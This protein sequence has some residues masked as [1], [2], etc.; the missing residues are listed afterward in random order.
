VFQQCLKENAI[1]VFWKPLKIMKQF[2]WYF[3][4]FFAGKIKWVLLTNLELMCIFF[5]AH[6]RLVQY[7]E[8]IQGKTYFCCAECSLNFV[9]LLFDSFNLYE[10]KVNFEQQSS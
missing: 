5:P 9:S 1:L 8:L 7:L 3:T 6:L 4:K 10:T 2:E